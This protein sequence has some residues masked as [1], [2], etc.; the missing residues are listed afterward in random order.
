MTWLLVWFRRLQPCWSSWKHSAQ[1]GGTMFSWNFIWWWFHFLKDFSP[2]VTWRNDPKVDCSAYNFR[3]VVENQ[4]PAR[5]HGSHHGVNTSKI[6]S[7]F[8]TINS[9]CAAVVNFGS[10]FGWK[11]RSV[12]ASSS[13]KFDIS[14]SRNQMHCIVYKG[15]ISVRLS[16]A[17]AR[18][19]PTSSIFIH[20]GGRSYP[21][22]INFVIRFYH[23]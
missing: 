8:W 1:Y 2:L 12:S 22:C 10:R 20:F 16:P 6:L 4:P 9:I 11:P 23:P 3:K 15:S 14:G 17:F 13:F 18:F 5:F 7:D 21:F 19:H